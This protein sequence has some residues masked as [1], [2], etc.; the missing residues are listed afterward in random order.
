MTMM[1]GTLDARSS[2]VDYN[3]LKCVPSL[4]RSSRHLLR[5]EDLQSQLMLRDSLQGA[6]TLAQ[7]P[8]LL[9]EMSLQLPIRSRMPETHM[10]KKLKFRRT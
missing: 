6:G 9:T 5:T 8:C 7:A 3:G 4:P 2:F 1:T 10:E